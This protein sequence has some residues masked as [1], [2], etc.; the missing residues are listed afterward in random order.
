MNPKPRYQ[1]EG[2]K[3]GAREGKQTK[4]LR[5]IFGKPLRNVVTKTKE[6]CKNRKTSP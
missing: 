1:N 2:I 6:F 4:V 5:R 3:G